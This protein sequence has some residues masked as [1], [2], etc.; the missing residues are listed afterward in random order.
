MC[1]SFQVRRNLKTWQSAFNEFLVITALD[2]QSLVRIELLHCSI[3]FLSETALWRPTHIKCVTF[4]CVRGVRHFS[5]Y[6]IISWNWRFQIHLTYFSLLYIHFLINE[7]CH[8]TEYA[9]TQRC[10]AATTEHATDLN[11]T[12]TYPSKYK[13][14]TGAFHYE[15]LQ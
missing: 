14:Y 11:A 7:P 2:L 13:L 9:L 8:I 12:V 1:D 6:A 5:R 3:T 15:R 4:L 10:P